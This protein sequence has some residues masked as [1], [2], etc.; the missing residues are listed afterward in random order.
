MKSKSD[1]IETLKN[2]I[3]ILNKSERSYIFLV[4]K[5]EDREVLYST[6]GHNA[7]LDDVNFVSM[8]AEG[9]LSEIKRQTFKYFAENGHDLLTKVDKT[10]VN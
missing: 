2:G 7:N 8:I 6:R 5:G 9:L 3:E 4:V 10:C 1:M